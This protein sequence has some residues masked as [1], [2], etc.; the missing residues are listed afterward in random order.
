MNMC[1]SLLLRL[2]S[3]LN[4][5]LAIAIKIAVKLWQI[6][7]GTFFRDGKWYISIMVDD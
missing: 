6:Y 1:T 3:Q 2:S 7:A 5:E 4:D